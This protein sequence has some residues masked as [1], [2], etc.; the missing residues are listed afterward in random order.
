MGPAEETLTLS[1]WS[2]FYRIAGKIIEHVDVSALVWEME[3]SSRLK[4]LTSV[5]VGAAEATEV[6]KPEERESRA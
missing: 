6:M 3:G 4:N 5:F 2:F 1:T